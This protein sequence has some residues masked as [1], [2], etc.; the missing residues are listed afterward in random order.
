MTIDLQDS[1][2]RATVSLATNSMTER[3]LFAMCLM[4]MTIVTMMVMAIITMMVMAIITMMVMTTIT[5][6]VRYTSR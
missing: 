4:M 1:T 5:M 3:W 2:Q 6:M